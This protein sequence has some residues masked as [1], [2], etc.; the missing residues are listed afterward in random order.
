MPAPA[1]KLAVLGQVSSYQRCGRELGD[2]FR[3]LLGRDALDIQCGIPGVLVPV[4]VQR[5]CD[6]RLA[7]VRSEFNQL[8]RA[9]GV[10]ELL[11]PEAL[12]EV[13]PVK[14]KLVAVPTGAGRRQEA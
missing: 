4:R 14:L 11:A 9:V 13:P 1:A 2:G 5:R 7:A 8:L 12:G 3:K 6:E 10:A